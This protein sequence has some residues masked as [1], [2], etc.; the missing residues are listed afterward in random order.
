MQGW[1]YV[2]VII[3]LFS[4]QVVGW[5]IDDHMRTSLCANALQMAFYPQGTSGGVSLRPA[6]CIIPIKVA[7]MRAEN[8]VT[9]WPS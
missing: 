4:R 5:A 6:Y 1:L 7:K 8:I 2:A 9:I 3:D